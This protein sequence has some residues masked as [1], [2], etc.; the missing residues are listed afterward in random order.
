MLNITPLIYGEL[1]SGDRGDFLHVLIISCNVYKEI[2]DCH[3]FNKF[4]VPKQNTISF[5]IY[6]I[7]RSNGKLSHSPIV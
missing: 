7:L 1:F 4:H 6:L 2:A 3:F 5:K